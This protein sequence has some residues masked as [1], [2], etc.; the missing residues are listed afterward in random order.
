MII[1]IAGGS[2]SGKST[3]AKR[4]ATATGA[5]HLSMDSY[6]KPYHRLPDAMGTDGKVYKD[7]NCP[8]AF[9]TERLIRDVKSAT[10]NLIL[11]GLLIL[12]EK[13]LRDL[14]DLRIFLDC[15]ADIRVVRRIRRNLSHGMSMDDVTS[16]YLALVRYRHEEYVALSAGYADEVWDTSADTDACFQSLLERFFPQKVDKDGFFL[17]NEDIT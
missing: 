13:E 8:E 10:G 6:Y 2:A 9:D 16:V 4:L 12:H 11:E 17:Y 14:C 15:P 7:F 5:T 1:G 3:L